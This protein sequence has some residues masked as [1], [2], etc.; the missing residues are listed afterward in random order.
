MVDKSY[1]ERTA[2]GHSSTDS[3]T[4]VDTIV[5]EF[6]LN[7]EQ[8]R[9]FCIIANHAC[10]PHS[11]QLK[12][13]IGGM[14]GTG[15]TQVLK[16]LISFFTARNESHRFVV[17]AP[18]GSAAAL[19]AGS[20]Y[21]YFFGFDERSDEQISNVK[22][23]QVKSRMQGVEYVFFDEVSMLSCRDLYRICARLAIVF[24]EMEAPFGGLNMIFAGDFA[25]LPPAIG[26]EHASLYSR[27]VGSTGSH[28]D[29]EA[30]IGKALWHQITTVVLLQ[31]NMRQKT[32]SQADAQLHQALTNMRY[33][34]CIPED[35]VFLRSLV[36]SKVP[37]HSSV[38]DKDFRQVSIITAMNIHKDEINR[39]GSLRFA[40]ETSQTLIDFFSE[41]NVSARDEKKSARSAP[42][43]IR[44][45]PV[46]SDRV[47]QLIWSQP[48]SANTKNIPGKLSLCV[49]MPV[50]IRV[51]S[52]T[53]LC[54]TKG[55]EATVHSWQS[56]VGSRGQRM[57]E[58]LFVTL[59]NPPQSVKIEGL[60]ENVVPLTRTSAHINC[61]LPDDTSININ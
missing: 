41:D 35:L 29:Q 52:A 54:I 45:V 13:Y 6:R 10:T 17:V 30:A 60:P 61:M 36:S 14:G 40:R 38:G 34:A 28:Q 24:G 55:Q 46:I 23:A 15:K 57:L 4:L 31:E 3:R 25:Q 22:L 11:E 1:L 7:C 59:I 16:A 48:P 21:H 37:G 47:Q 51:N 39:L 44:G 53:E 50:M 19:L 58:T 12:M 42:K 8:E 20:T 5:A 2:T 32:Q 27:T 49:G 56:T 43:A 18:T 9:A 33:K 26:Q